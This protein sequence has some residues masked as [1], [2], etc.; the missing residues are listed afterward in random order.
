MAEGLQVSG[1][2]VR[3]FASVVAAAGTELTPAGVQAAATRVAGAVPGSQLAGA[4]GELAGDAEGWIRSLSAACETWSQ[5]VAAAL[6]EFE[7][8]DGYAADRARRMG[9]PV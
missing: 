2:R 1:D 7:E 6:Q 5:D 3:I 4:F 8:S 9:R